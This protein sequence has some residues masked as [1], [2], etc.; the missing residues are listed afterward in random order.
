LFYA[1]SP[2]LYTLR[3]LQYCTYCTY[4]NFQLIKCTKHLAGREQDYTAAHEGGEEEEGKR[5]SSPSVEASFGGWGVGA[6]W[7]RGHKKSETEKETGIGARKAIPNRIQHSTRCIAQLTS[8][9]P[10][11]Q[12]LPFRPTKQVL[13]P[14]PLFL[15]STL[16]ERCSYSS[17]HLILKLQYLYERGDRLGEAVGVK[18][19]AGGMTRL[20]SLTHS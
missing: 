7:V 1:I 10:N 3:Y 17:V 15:T 14:S 16:E 6:L 20:D 19:D 4:C 12:R 11:P 9:P 18:P 2:S 13:Q 5:A 8:M